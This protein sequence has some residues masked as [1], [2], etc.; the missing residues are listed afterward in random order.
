MIKPIQLESADGNEIWNILTV[1]GP[2]LRRERQ[3]TTSSSGYSGN[4]RFNGDAL[5]CFR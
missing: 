5:A 2:I 3:W 1:T 4:D